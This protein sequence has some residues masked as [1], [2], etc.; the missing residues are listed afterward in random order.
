MYSEFGMVLI[1]IGGFGISDLL[2]KWLKFSDTI[3]LLYF[4]LVT[5]F[6]YIIYYFAID[7][8]EMKN[9]NKKLL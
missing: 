8:S 1:Y 7:R 2:L 6:G 5:I 3:S 4:F 9:N